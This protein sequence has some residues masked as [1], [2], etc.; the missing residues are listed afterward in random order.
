[1]RWQ[2]HSRIV[3]RRYCLYM[4]QGMSNPQ[5]MSMGQLQVC[6]RMPMCISPVVIY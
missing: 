6:A 5:I 3:G 4:A 2:L 1:M